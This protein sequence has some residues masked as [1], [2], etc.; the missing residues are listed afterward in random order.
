MGGHPLTLAGPRFSWSGQLGPPTKGPAE[1]QAQRP[2]VGRGAPADLPIE[3][4]SRRGR[5]EGEG[6]PGAVLLVQALVLKR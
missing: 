1:Q 6:G 4:E 5:V 2:P 3:V